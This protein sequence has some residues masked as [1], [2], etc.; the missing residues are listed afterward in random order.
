MRKAFPFVCVSGTPHERGIQ[1]GRAAGDRIRKSVEIYSRAFDAVKLPWKDVFELARAFVPRIVKYDPEYLEEMAGIAAGAELELEKV[2][3]LNARTELLYRGRKGPLTPLESTEGCTAAVAMPDVTAKGRL[4]H[5]QN[6]DW[7]ADC[8]DSAIVIRHE[9]PDGMAY[10]GFNEAGTLARAGFNN[11]GV[12][13]TGNFLACD[14][15]LGGEGIPIPFVRRRVL[16]SK[17]FDEAV[18]AIYDSPRSFSNNLMVSQADGQA[19]NLE[20]TPV[21]I[22]RVEH[23]RGLIVHANHFRSPVAKATVR[24]TGIEFSPDSIYRDARVEERLQPHLGLITEAHMKEALADDFGSPAA[25]CRAPTPGPGGADCAT[26]ATIV[27]DAA[28]GKMWIAPTPYLG[29]PAYTEY[30][31]Q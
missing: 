18:A 7:I 3:A 2:I 4:L 23:E 22:F 29:Q 12:A 31:I 15:D 1:L 10:L 5:A 13:L 14:R 21:E 27:M 20:T 19:V 25:V 17:S 16:T 30:S 26:V 24:D 8:V 11:C 6:W 9:M 28:A